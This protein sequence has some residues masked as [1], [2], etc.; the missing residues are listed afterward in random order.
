MNYWI[1]QI[2]VQCRLC[3]DFVT[4]S[5]NFQFLKILNA[6]FFDVLTVLFMAS[7]KQNETFKQYEAGMAYRSLVDRNEMLRRERASSLCSSLIER[8]WRHP[9][10]FQC[11]S[12]PWR[13]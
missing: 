1:D 10:Q 7:E 11:L 8:N 4:A 12:P 2:T 9:I 5:E 3:T 13:T 6:I